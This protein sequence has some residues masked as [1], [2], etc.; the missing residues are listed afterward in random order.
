MKQIIFTF[1]SLCLLT[2][3]NAKSDA[4]H[5]LGNGQ[6]LVYERQSDILQLIG[7]PYSTPSTFSLQLP[8]GYEVVSEREKGGAIWTHRIS[9]DG[10]AVAEITD[11]VVSGMPCFVRKINAFQAFHY[12]SVLLTEDV[13]DIRA[14]YAIGLQSALLM[15][16]PRGTPF[17]ND[18]PLINNLYN[19]FLTIGSLSLHGDKLLVERGEGVLYVTGGL[20]PDC[21]E[22]AT[23]VL[24]APYNDLLQQTRLYWADFTARRRDFGSLI[25]QNAPQRDKLLQTI[26]D[27]S[28]ML[29]CQQANEGA[30][31]A[32]YNYHL[33]YVR[34]QYG[35]SRGLLA[36]GYADEA[37]Q[38]LDFYY[39][40]WCKEGKIQNAQGVGNF[41]FHV[42]E[43]DN[44]E[45]TGYLLV[46]AFD[47]LQSTG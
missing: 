12:R 21:S 29:K 34:D 27:V 42:H 14:E 9:K 19:R 41:A 5:C 23:A 20:Y 13:T 32:G 35:V 18:Y 46:Q 47:Y 38:I 6:M 3:A 1:I 22:T 33:G 10:V 26:D 24:N 7:N 31:I 11:F 2:P 45:I 4:V 17:Y 28:V 25:P 43:N 15:K 36:L 44:V 40:I 16:T 39:R 8:G 37:R 30:V